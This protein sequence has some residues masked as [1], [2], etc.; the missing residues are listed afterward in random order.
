MSYSY[1]YIYT[2]IHN[3]YM[4]M[5]IYVFR[6]SRSISGFQGDVSNLPPNIQK[7]AHSTLEK[8]AKREDG[9][10]VILYTRSP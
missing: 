5:C 8:T 3:I 2:Y 10:A 1:I 9:E 7:S 4:C 6:I